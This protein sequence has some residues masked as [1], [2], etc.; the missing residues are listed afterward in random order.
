MRPVANFGTVQSDACVW[1]GSAFA[2]SIIDACYMQAELHNG[3]HSWTFNV[4]FFWVCHGVV[5]RMS[6]LEPK[7]ELHCF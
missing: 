3:I 7:T 5:V 1:F 6:I 2:F 4:V